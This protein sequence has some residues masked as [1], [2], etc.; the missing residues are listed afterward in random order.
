MAQ[1]MVN[2]VRREEE[3]KPKSNAAIASSQVWNNFWESG[4]INVTHLCKHYGKQYFHWHRLRG[5]KDMIDEMAMAITLRGDDA[6]TEHDMVIL[7]KGGSDED[8]ALVCVS[9]A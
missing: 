3:D 4:Y 6:L 5:T 1:E 9:Y 7:V 8:R 2:F